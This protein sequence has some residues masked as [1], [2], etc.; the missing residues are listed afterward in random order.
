MSPQTSLQLYEPMLECAKGQSAAAEADDWAS[1]ERFAVERAQLVKASGQALAEGRVSDLKMAT[2]LIQAILSTDQ[3]TAQLLE[4]KRN[5]IRLEVARFGR[6][7]A[8]RAAYGPREITRSGGIIDA[9]A[10]F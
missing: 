4:A 1:Y 3:H 2:V 10:A 6:V 8:A 5:E 7:A 9:D